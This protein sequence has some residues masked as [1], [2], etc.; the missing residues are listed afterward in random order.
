VARPTCKSSANGAEFPQ[1][2]SFEHRGKVGDG[3]HTDGKQTC[4][5]NPF[6][7]RGVFGSSPFGRKKRSYE[8]FWHLNQGHP[9]RGAGKGEHPR[10]S[11]R[12]SPVRGSAGAALGGAA[13]ARVPG[14]LRSRRQLLAALARNSF[15]RWAVGER[16]ALVSSSTPEAAAGPARRQGRQNRAKNPSDSGLRR[17]GA[18]RPGSPRGM[19]TSRR[20]GA[21]AFEPW[22]KLRFEGY[23][24]RGRPI[25]PEFGAVPHLCAPG[26][27]RWVGRVPWTRL[28]TARPGASTRLGGR[29]PAEHARKTR[30][31]SSK[32]S[33]CGAT[34]DPR[35]RLLHGASADF[36]AV[37]ARRRGTLDREGRRRPCGRGGDSVATRALEQARGA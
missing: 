10:R 22:A 19:G 6:W 11:A 23:A 34:S 2:R 14:L 9:G 36:S 7:F 15:P 32:T 8:V 21:F 17:R 12:G 24:A 5:K 4:C 1:N 37:S 33:K 27:L 29:P 30:R 3:K 18:T 31:R 25:P 16:G 20:T 13:T 35:G 26:N 28:G